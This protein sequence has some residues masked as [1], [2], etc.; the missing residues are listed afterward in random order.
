[1][2]P[3]ELRLRDFRSYR[4]EG[5]VF[6]FRERRLVG[7][8]G[9]IGS[10]KSSLLD[11]MALA[12]YGRTPAVG[13]SVRSLI[14]QRADGG[15]V[16][17]RFEVDGQVWEVMRSLRRKGQSQHVLTLLSGDT[18]DAEALEKITQA[19][20]VTEKVVELLGLDFDAFTRSVLL[21]Q[22]RFA[23]FLSAR[24]AQRDAVLKGV[25]GHER[26][27][28]MRELARTRSAE[29]E[30]AL[31]VV[32]GRLD[33]IDEVM[34][35]LADR[36]VTVAE[37]TARLEILEKAEPK[38]TDLDRRIA[39][40]GKSLEEVDLALGTIDRLRDRMPSRPDVER[41][42]AEGAG[43]AERRA[44]LAESLDAAQSALQVAEEEAA[45]EPALR[46]TIEQAAKLVA[47]TP[48]LHETLRK[49]RERQEQ[50]AKLEAQRSAE[51]RTFA[52]RVEVARAAL[53]TTQDDLTKAEESVAAAAA[54]LDDGRH[55]DMAA[56]LRTSLAA[57][58]PC[59][60]CDQ[61]VH[62]LP[63]PRSSVDLDSL[64]KQLERARSTRSGAE[65][66][67]RAAA[68][69]AEAARLALA[70][71][72]RDAAGA[73]E[74]HAAES[75]LVTEAE[76]ALAAHVEE[77]SGVLG[78]EDTDTALSG[79][80]KQ[81]AD[82]TERRDAARRNVEAVRRTHD[83][84]IKAEQAVGRNLADLQSSINAVVAAL[85]LDIAV[86]DG[87][88]KALGK[89]FDELEAAW[90]ARVTT[91]KA[92][93]Q[94]ASAQLETAR[95]EHRALL[96]ELEVVDF[97]AERTKAQTTL[98]LLGAQIERDE[99]VVAAAEGDIEERDRLTLDVERYKQVASDL[100]D[101]RFV[102]YLL[103]DER[104]RLADLGSD[105]FQDLSSG[106]YR[107]SGEE[108]DI[109]D[110]AA[111]EGQRK[112]ES[113]SGGETFLASLALA[114]GLAEMVSRSGGRLD[115]FFLDEGF[116][117]LDPEHLSLAMDGIER[118]I[119]GDGER[120]VVVVSHVPEMRERIEDL[121]VL[122]KDPTTGDTVVRRG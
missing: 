108:F 25:F 81:L 20:D 115:A 87:S 23:E 73:A 83:E 44:E 22:G 49:T 98:D 67:R 77:L 47:L 99:A 86:P 50:V 104:V 26:L 19:D 42:V 56:A 40:A 116:G 45:D 35:A 94:E 38:L 14:H 12:L 101:S 4:G 91:A 102:R 64:E 72:E 105:H 33:R 70:T 41:V 48:S 120:L 96:E 66:A 97:E 109:I 74:S 60:V 46:Q 39:D 88:A 95:T 78:S 90:E 7:V 89:A 11:A 63:P 119:T 9:P 113:L 103:D 69:D 84:A 117:S 80:R 58:S 5:H 57:G 112:S 18:D 79:L 31:G 28:V 92:T 43:A 10:G 100:T 3:L 1:M 2:R 13:K 62:E 8:V 32:T 34:A 29:A 54:A 114:L 17:L 16:S 107:F 53:A 76:A 15:G 106:R 55:A 65:K 111:A 121:I 51:A 93:R 82:L 110:L 27:G 52:E 24:P 6:D 68:D 85:S 37:T 71:A 59:P 21:A 61:D 75:V 122:D 118:L 30:A 36:K